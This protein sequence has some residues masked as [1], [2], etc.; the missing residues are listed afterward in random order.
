MAKNCH[1]NIFL[2]LAL[3]SANHF[4]N[5]H[6][7]NYNEANDAVALPKIQKEK[8]LDGMDANLDEKQWFLY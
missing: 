7:L 5:F 3:S 8:K 2:D 4:W 6:A 1:V